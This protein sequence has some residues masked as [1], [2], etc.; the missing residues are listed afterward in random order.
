ME[1]LW[2]NYASQIKSEP[3]KNTIFPSTGKKPTI[4]NSHF[5]SETEHILFLSKNRKIKESRNIKKKGFRKQLN[6]GFYLH[7][8]GMTY[9]GNIII[10]GGN[11][12][13]HIY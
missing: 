7:N 10:L 1:R 3:T 9:R 11:L 13:L 4:S 2:T 12:I 6:L 5:G 8:H